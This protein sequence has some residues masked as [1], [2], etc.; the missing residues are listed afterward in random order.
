[1]ASMIEM[2]NVTLSYD[3]EERRI[4]AVKDID[5]SINDGEYVSIVGP[6]GSGKSS[7]LHLMAGFLAP[8]KGVVLHNSETVPVKGV[9]AQRY[10]SSVIGFIFQNYGLIPSL[11]SVQNVM[12]P[13]LI[14]GC[15]LREAE[16]R[17]RHALSSVGL[18]ECANRRP[19]KLSGGEQQRI[20]IARAMING[21]SLILADEPTGNLDSDSAKMIVDALEGV[22]DAGC[23]LVMVT[24]D[25][26]LASRAD[27]V[28]VLEKGKR[29]S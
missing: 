21:P 20:A 1:M 28:V 11:S 6:S 7:I 19:A 23:T 26:E 22:C 5:L 13:L 2:K 29:I 14:D 17:A 10:R 24:H 16:D 27:R 25:Q 4:D 9:A 12:I 8:T 15:G 3:T 18:G